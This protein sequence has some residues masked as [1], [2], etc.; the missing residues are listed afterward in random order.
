MD[1]FG[2]PELIEQTFPLMTSADINIAVSTDEISNSGKSGN[3]VRLH[4]RVKKVEI[5][6]SER[7]KYYSFYSG[8]DLYNHTEN[9]PLQTSDFIFNEEGEI[10]WDLGCGRGER[11]IELAKQNKDKKYVGV[12]FHNRSL[13]MGIKAA[14]LLNLNN[15]HFVR[16][17]ANQIM[18]R[19]PD[20]TAEQVAI[21]FPA[22]QPNSKG[23]FD[24]ILQTSMAQNIHRILKFGQTFEFATDSEPYFNVKMRMLGCL[25]LFECSQSDIT[26]SVESKQNDQFSNFKPVETRYQ[27]LWE[28]KG[29]ITHRAKIRKI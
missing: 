22:P 6:D 1:I 17:D 14:S 8:N 20:E 11:I 13:D 21:L 3:S 4:E 2:S 29:I 25:G 26:H 19:I 28:S 12:D 27:Q 23:G 18:K 10:N 9:V 7:E 15:I 24:D 16:A 5:S